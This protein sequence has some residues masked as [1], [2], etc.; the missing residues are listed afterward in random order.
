M[1]GL[2]ADYIAILSSRTLENRRQGLEAVLECA[3]GYYD[4]LGVA[5]RVSRLSGRYGAA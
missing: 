4:A 5:D 1:Q 3:Q 2:K